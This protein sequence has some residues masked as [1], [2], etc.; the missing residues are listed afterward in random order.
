MPPDDRALLVRFRQQLARRFG[1]RYIALSAEV[2]TR[3]HADSWD[4]RKDSPD[5][6]GWL[7]TRTLRTILSRRVNG[8]LDAGEPDWLA[9]WSDLLG[10]EVLE[11]H[12]YVFK[13]TAQE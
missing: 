2:T 8:M 6:R 4:K 7:G 1:D 11:V 3:V 12:Q 9:F 5:K 13:K 10:I